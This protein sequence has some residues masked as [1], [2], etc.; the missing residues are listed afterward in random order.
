MHDIANFVPLIAQLLGLAPTTL[1]FG[2]FLVNQGAKVLGRVIPNDKKG[3]LG[4]VRKVSKILGADPSSKITSGVS[5]QDIAK[6]SIQN[7]IL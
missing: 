5:V 2:I 4:V 3:V 1:L 6:A 7:K